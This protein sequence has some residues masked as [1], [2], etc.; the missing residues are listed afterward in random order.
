MTM[1]GDVRTVAPASAL[2]SQP[3]NE[4]APIRRR[5]LCDAR[6]AFR[7][8]AHLEAAWPTEEFLERP[9]F[10][11]A[12]AGVNTVFCQENR[13]VISKFPRHC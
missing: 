2:E 8:Q 9:D 12:L 4:Y 11:A 5:M 1:A 13:S 10:D 3:L 6:T 7:G